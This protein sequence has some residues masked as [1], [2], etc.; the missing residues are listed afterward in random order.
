MFDRVLAKA[1]D[2]A[3]LSASPPHPSLEGGSGREGGGGYKTQG[4]YKIVQSGARGAREGLGGVLW[5]IR[6][7]QPAVWKLRGREG[8][9]REG[10]RTPSRPAI[11]RV[12][13]Q[14]S[15]SAAK[16]NISS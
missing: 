12:R 15:K 13:S 14:G 10:E 6:G 16:N 8:N 4:G 2:E 11:G 3:V 1:A 9:V 5:K 7:L